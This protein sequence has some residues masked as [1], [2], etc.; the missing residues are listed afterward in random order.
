MII[1]SLKF[2]VYA[3]L[4]VDG[5]PYYIGK[6]SKNRAYTRHSGFY[7]PTDK[8]RIVIIENNLTELG[9]FALE[10]RYIRWYGRKNNGTGILRNLT[11]GGEGA[12]GVII[13]EETRKKLSDAKSGD[14]HPRGMLGKKMSEE[15]SQKK[16][17][18]LSGKNKGRILGNQSEEWIEKRVGHR[19]NI[20]REKA[21]CPHCNKTGGAPQMK[22]WHFDN[23]KNNDNRRID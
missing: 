7:P 9:A 23:C 11:D 16:S 1:D 12:S 10:R 2:Y 3:Y 18:S 13:S 14:K 17:K 21:T 4:R 5:S 19:R 20:P 6:G 8:S 22:Q 15:S